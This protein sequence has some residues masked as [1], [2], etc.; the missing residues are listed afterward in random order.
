MT[1]TYRLTYFAVSLVFVAYAWATFFGGETL[2]SILSPVAVAVVSLIFIRLLHRTRST[3]EKVFFA[4]LLAGTVGWLLAD[5]WDFFM[6]HAMH[7]VPEDT[8][9]YYYVYM[10]PNFFFAASA[11]FL[12]WQTRDKERVISTASDGIM[13]V[14]I[15]VA[16][17]YIGFFNLSF[18]QFTSMNLSGFAMLIYAITDIIILTAALIET[19]TSGRKFFKEGLDWIML[20]IA[21]YA[22]IDLFYTYQFFA[23]IYEPFGI[24]D[25]IY[26]LSFF[27]LSLGGLKILD[28]IRKGLLP[29][30]K[31]HR[32]RVYGLK[33]GRIASLLAAP[34][35]LIA[36]RTTHLYELLVLLILIISYEVIN[37]TFFA[38]RENDRSLQDEVKQ[39]AL[40]ETQIKDRTRELS[41]KN[42][43]LELISRSDSISTLMNRRYFM[44]M[45][46]R[47]I[48][49]LPEDEIIS[50]L[51]I[52]LD[53]FK[54]VNDVYGHSVGDKMLIEIARRLKRFKNDKSLIARQGGDEFVLAFQGRYTNDEI[55][56]LTKAIISDCAYPIE[57]EPF[58]FR[59][60]ISIGITVYPRDATESETLL[61]NADIAMYHAKEFSSSSYIFFD[62]LHD[63]NFRRRTQIEILL[64]KANFDREFVLHYQPIFTPQGRLV[65]LEAL[66][67]WDAPGIGMISPAEFVPI[68]E[69]NGVIVLLGEWI[70]DQATRR[71]ADWNRRYHKSLRIGINI[72][73]L[74]LRNPGFTEHLVATCNTNH[75]KLSWIDLEITESI[76]VS[77]D[78]I[79]QL[80]DRIAMHGISVSIDDFGTGYS[81]LNYIRN[82]NIT[83]LK[84]AKPL[85]DSITLSKQGAQIVEIVIEM[86]KALDLHVIAEGV[87]EQS[88][89]DFLTELGCDTIQGYLFGRPVAEAIFETLYLDPQATIEDRP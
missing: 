81:S 57:I 56:I 87:E 33:Y 82:L 64:K 65:A 15:W 17:M 42:E 37:D 68:A 14:V 47:M 50:V 74:Q 71:I 89:L 2:T 36:I 58:E 28:E 55:E 6:I 27:I 22:L 45:L 16:A 80:L 21:I 79:S 83:N 34:M 7:I 75:A 1:K 48:K 44:E 88:Q 32:E 72:S 25:L 31:I 62:T 39:H 24:T 61:R 46:N 51:F 66:L 11:I 43:E 9:L 49:E 69:E 78:T 10:M 73:S 41:E 29:R 77:F 5:I 30:I 53:K 8:L 52:D 40:L 3:F 26:L 23:N 63:D 59:I 19:T 38:T 86:A 70:I 76:A 67:R 20:G 12:L 35:L 18:S 54:S 4:L 84:I 13:I 85:I 60:A